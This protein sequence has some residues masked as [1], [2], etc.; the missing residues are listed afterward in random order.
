MANLFLIMR[1][2]IIL[3]LCFTLSS[4]ITST[5]QYISL[6]KERISLK[7]V[8]REISKQSKYHFFYDE[9]DI[10]VIQF[11]SLNFNNAPI[12]VVL[13]KVV[14]D[15]GLVYEIISG[16]VI[17]TKGKEK[18]N[19]FTTN[20]VGGNKE[21]SNKLD[22]IQQSKFV[23]V[24]GIVT[25]ENK[26]PL[27]G[28]TV[29]NSVSKTVSITDVNGHYSI[30][31]LVNSKLEFSMIG[32]ISSS[33]RVLD[34]ESD[35]IEHSLILLDNTFEVE[36][37][38]ATGYQ[39]FKRSV[40]PGSISSVKMEDLTQLGAISVDQMLEG[41]I[42]GMAV[43]GIIGNP[44]APPKIRVRGTSSITGDQEPIWVVDGVIWDEPVPIRNR[45]LASADDITLFNMVGGSIAG[46]NPNDI[47][48]IDVLKDAS[49]TAIYG[50]KAVNGVIVV[51]TKKG[52]SGR[53]RVNYSLNMQGK[54]RPS[55][56]QFNLMNAAERLSTAEEIYRSGAIYPRFPGKTSY[57]GL[58]LKF[59]R[60]EIDQTE[61]DERVTA[62]A[63]NNTD[64]FDLLFRNSLSQNHT[65]SMS[66]GTENS[67]YY[68]SG[69][70]Y[71][72]QSN[73][74]GAGLQRY[75]GSI[76]LVNKFS[77]KFE[78]DVKIGI[79][80]RNN[81]GFHPS[82]N[83]YDYAVSTSRALPA[84]TS[85]G[86][87]FFYEVGNPSLI[88]GTNY[89]HMFNI[90]NELNETKSQST[91]KEMNSLLNLHWKIM[92]WLN[93]DGTFSYNTTQT[94]SE[95]WA[96]E[97]SYNVSNGL[98]AFGKT[99]RGFP[100]GLYKI[101][102]TAYDRSKLPIGGTLLNDNM[103]SSN[104]T[105]R[106]QLM[107]EHSLNNTHRFN[108]IL[109][110]EVRST[111]YV[112][113]KE[114]L[115]GFFP[116]RGKMIIPPTTTGYKDYLSEFKPVRFTD[117]AS[118]YF[119]L[120]SI[121]NYSFKDKYIFSNSVRY[122]G[123]NVFGKDATYRFLPVW[124]AAGKWIVSEEDFLKNSRLVSFMALRS[125]Y[126]L[127]G[128]I[129]SDAS[130]SLVINVNN[131]D[132]ETGKYKASIHS[133]PNPNLRW[134]KTSSFNFGYELGLLNSLNMT[135]EYYYKK[136]E[137]LIIDKSVSTVS[138]RNSIL[139]N[140]GNMENKG[141]ELTLSA[142]PIKQDKFSWRSTLI[143][144]RNTNKITRAD[145][146]TENVSNK[147]ER[148]NK[149]TGKSVIEGDAYGTL[150]AYKYMGLNEKGWPLF[151][152]QDGTKGFMSSENNVVMYP[153]GSSEPKVS[154]GFDN[155]FRYKDFSLSVS[156]TFNLGYYK[157]L[158][159]YYEQETSSSGLPDHYENYPREFGNRWK[160][161]GDEL[162]T[163]TPVLMDYIQMITEGGPHGTP[164]ENGFVYSLNTST[165]VHMHELYNKSDLRVVKADYIRLRA[166]NLL[167]NI[168]SRFI[169]RTPINQISASLSVQNLGFWAPD[170][171]RFFGQDP[172]LLGNPYATPIPLI[173]NFG[174]NASF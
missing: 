58:L 143:G 102:S 77:D 116:D 35:K 151:A 53:A 8:F 129:R 31:S 66:G 73:A 155:T 83:P 142:F 160:K 131:L 39:T 29:V 26:K 169:K 81:K 121:L 68:F 56:A 21:G 115:Y 150:Y 10:G 46:L 106:N 24:S 98:D 145:I 65:I 111:S 19:V 80:V 4:Y 137:N 158:H 84:F 104:Y 34:T 94:L 127:Q 51:T 123:S 109:G 42:A 114:L 40:V 159:D 49:A 57:E 72:E 13:K 47:E 60:K 108:L 119:S 130:P 167:Y 59:L 5:A 86:D 95:Q 110:Q 23:V 161:P 54:E 76:R 96:T 162:F 122:D 107:A 133:L 71:D 168:P 152:I 141:V 144:G 12:E 22:L 90:F 135:L 125:S 103:N 43:T 52:K 174:I 2:I 136:G 45:D 128:N 48:S 15:S 20:V 28:V 120:F 78:A 7:E 79:G 16:T 70:F 93:W 166:V 124:S 50:V 82:I 3:T 172:E 101:G 64:W 156:L 74:K 30:K 99:Q 154:G 87:L 157:R 126:G 163:T 1:L 140:S 17:V 138:G 67:S 38:V 89:F 112:G 113:N 100:Y 134:E 165:G 173:I 88:D 118:N 92:P 11:S 105:V 27:P 14:E 62:L 41:K 37:V 25:D 18:K 75:N 148:T 171:D 149:L 32:R 146:S 61:F 139:L 6:R 153:I 117:K 132:V 97:H 69:G 164:T 9:K 85:N 55:Y 36:S 44:G 91:A 147:T 33:F 63:V 170:K